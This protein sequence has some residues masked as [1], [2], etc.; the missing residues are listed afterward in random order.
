[1]PP[2]ESW[3]PTPSAMPPWMACTFLSPVRSVL[4]FSVVGG[5]GLVGCEMWGWGGERAR[6]GRAVSERGE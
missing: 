5:E 6:I 2:L 3:P 1:M 4:S